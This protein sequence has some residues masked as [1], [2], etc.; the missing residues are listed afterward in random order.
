MT[1]VSHVDQADHDLTKNP[2]FGMMVSTAKEKRTT[3][4]LCRGTYKLDRGVALA[5]TKLNAVI[6]VEFLDLVGR[7]AA[8][9]KP[10]TKP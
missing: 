5:R 4:M 3:S 9:L 8:A 1:T 2:A 7:Y 10:R 6:P